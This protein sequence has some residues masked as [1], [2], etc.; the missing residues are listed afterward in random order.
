MAEKTVQI[1]LTLFFQTIDFLENLDLRMPQPALFGYHRV[2]LSAYLHKK[3]RM[4]LRKAY[5]DIIF[6]DNDDERREAR[7]EYLQ[8]KREAQRWC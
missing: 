6:A 7:M 8:K 5:S 1:P 4:G 2:I 3:Q